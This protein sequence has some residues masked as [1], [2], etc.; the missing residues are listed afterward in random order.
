[1][2]WKLALESLESKLKTTLVAVVEHHGSV[3]GKAGAMMVVSPTGVAGT[4]GGGLVEHRWISMA[5]QLE[6]A[7]LAEFSHDGVSTDSICSGLQVMVGLPLSRKDIPVIRRLVMMSE[8]GEPG[9]LEFRPEGLGIQP[10]DE[11]S[12]GVREK[13]QDWLARIS[14]GRPDELFI[15]GGGHVSLALSRIMATLPFRIKVF[16]TRADLPTMAENQWARTTRLDDWAGLSRKIP[17]G[18][19]SWAVIMTHGH[20]DDERVLQEILNLDLRYLGLMGSA[21]KVAQLYRHLQ[22]KGLNSGLLEKIHAPIGLPIRSH[23]P[24]EIAISIAAEIVGIR[25]GSSGK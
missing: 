1:M 12:L 20:R 5:R 8:T 11:R 18:P 15:A 21:A 25:N 24:E 19:H 17:E 23:T 10:F 6:T 14:F 7:H 2:L 3:P 16:D 9:V 4:V 13:G 22:G